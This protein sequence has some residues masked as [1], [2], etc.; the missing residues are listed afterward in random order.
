M[1]HDDLLRLLDRARSKNEAHQITG[2]L[3]YVQDQA[4]GRFVQ[5]LEGTK[6]E[7]KEIYQN[8]K[9]DSRH[10]HVTIISEGSIVARNFETWNMGFET[11][12]AEELQARPGHFELNE[13][14]L[15][16]KSVQKFNS[17]LSFLKSFY[18]MRS[19]LRSFN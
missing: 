13:D 15:K 18:S 1:Q 12:K 10:H 16:Q 9:Q 3:L 19:K 11:M 14:F 17:A 7:V 6:A 4:N 5:V 8:I 2:M